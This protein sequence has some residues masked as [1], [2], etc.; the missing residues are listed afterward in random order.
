VPVFTIRFITEKYAPS[1][2]VIMRWAPTWNIDRGGVYTDGAWTFELDEDKFPDGIEFKFVLTPGLWMG[3]SNLTV[4]RD[5]LAGTHDYEFDDQSN[6]FEARDAVIVERGVVPQRFFVR[7][8]DPMHQY[9]VLVVGSGMGGGLL[10]SRLADSGADVLLVEAGPYLFPTHVGNL[11]RRLKPGRF[12]K[13]IWSLWPDFR[14][15]NYA[16]GSAFRGG[17]GFNL[18]GRSLFWGGLIPRQTPWELAA[19]PETVR[20]YLLSGGYIAAEDAVNRVA[21]APSDY[22]TASRTALQNIFAGYDA[23]DAA[24][25]VQYRGFTNWSLPTGLFSTADLL[26]EDRLA[27]DPATPKPTVN[28]DIAVWRVDFDPADPTKAVGITGWDLI[29]QKQRSFSARTTVLCAGTIETAKI[30]LQSQFLDPNGK[31]GRGITD[32]TIRYRHFTLAPHSPHAS[33]TDSAKV[34]LRHPDAT[35]HRHAFDVVVELGADFNQ[36]RYVD[37]GHLARERAERADWMLCELVFMSYAPLADNNT[38]TIA[39][40]PAA[41]VTLNMNPVPPTDADAAEADALAEHLFAELRAQ[42]VLGEGTLEL[43]TADLGGVAHEVG[44]MRMAADGSGVVDADL[45][46]L[47]YSNLFVC[48][49]SVFPASPAANPS[50]TLAALALRLAE[51]LKTQ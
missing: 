34:V 32:H 38:L 7:N 22:Q 48:D 50:L 5:A 24:M 30:A 31:I 17:Q 14:V 8:L 27:D 10:A 16:P 29:A 36:G 23:E 13:H 15:Q 20:T 43:Q 4:S 49:N 39:G 19:W 51:H 37:P 46:V 18:G 9:D 2:T 21:P 33:T 40:D 1:Q 45:R 47:S 11:P 12:D 35:A 44:T 3:G 42:P 28:L 41:A 6:V 25:A 26:M